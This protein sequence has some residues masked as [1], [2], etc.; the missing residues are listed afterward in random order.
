M[1][2]ATVNTQVDAALNHALFN[3]LVELSL[4]PYPEI[5]NPEGCKKR[6]SVALILRIRPHFNHDPPLSELVPLNPT[7][8]TS[9][10]LSTFFAQPWVQHGDPEAIFIKRAAR[11]GDR[12]T[13]HV[14]LPGGKRD[15]EDA[16]DKAT[17]IREA[18]EEIGL[19]LASPDVLFVG[20]LPQ[21]VISSTWG[22][23][24]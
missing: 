19:D 12:W 6:A 13:S 24:P 21:R 17:A 10:I 23:V 3:T 4:N 2:T 11:E 18:V 1:S 9:E 22:K 7:Q 5:P 16:D 15:P 20:N 14:A 8:S